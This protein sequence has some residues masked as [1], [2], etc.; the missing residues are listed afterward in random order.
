[1]GQA[2][3]LS[4]MGQALSLSDM[5][6]ALSLSDMGQALFLSDMELLVGSCQTWGFWWVVVRHGTFGG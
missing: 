4:D 6:K 1:M 3:S 2:L 5:G